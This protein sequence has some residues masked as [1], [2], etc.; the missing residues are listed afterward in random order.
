MKTFCPISF[1]LQSYGEHPAILAS[2]GNHGPV[3]SALAF[4]RSLA[5]CGERR[6]RQE[7]DALVTVPNNMS[8]ITTA[9]GPWVYTVVPWED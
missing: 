7:K 5:N 2:A 1:F 8:S 9:N 4:F 3:N 6:S